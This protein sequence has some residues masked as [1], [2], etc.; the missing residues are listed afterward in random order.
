MLSRLITILSLLVF[1]ISMLTGSSV[2]SSLIK[3]T[4]VFFSLVAGFIIFYYLVSVIKQTSP[5]EQESTSN[6]SA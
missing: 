6:D 2:E 1:M 5:K 3:G 4:V